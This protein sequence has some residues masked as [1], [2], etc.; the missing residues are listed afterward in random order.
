P[1]LAVLGLTYSRALTASVNFGIT[2]NI[3]R[4]TI[5]EVNA[6]GI[7][8]DFGFTYETRFPGLTLGFVM[9]NYGPDLVFSGRGFDR[10]PADEKRPAS[11]R[12]ASSE[13]PT[14]L[15]IGTAYNF[16]SDDMSSAT[17]TA[18]FRANNQ[19]MDM[20]QGGLEYAY[21]QRYFVRGGYNYADQE[22]WLYGAT[23]GL[24]VM[25]PLG[26][27]DLTLEYCW[28]QTEVFD[29]NQYWTLKA[30]F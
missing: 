22:N 24:G 8:F 13:L 14:S 2:G 4:E 11:S 20:W 19:S 10:I 1:T 30:S 29:A 16:Y 17:A 23:L 25:V 26:T 6:T 9:K 12:N 28:T 21:D 27:T 15:N 18:N 3:I 5:F 7:A